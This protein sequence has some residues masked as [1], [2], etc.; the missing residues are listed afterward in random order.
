MHFPIISIMFRKIF[1]HAWC[2]S[3]RLPRKQC[4]KKI[5]T[6]FRDK[7]DKRVYYKMENQPRR[8]VSKSIFKITNLSWYLP[9]YFYGWMVVTTLQEPCPLYVSHIPPSAKKFQNKKN[10]YREK[11]S[12]I[13]IGLVLKI[14]WNFHFF[15]RRF[16]SFLPG[17]FLC[18]VA[19]VKIFLLFSRG[20]TWFLGTS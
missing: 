18:A 3:L 14:F 6:L 5:G 15:C 12:C 4:L 16:F 8:E 9:L 19:V 1:N 2:P 20:N 17:P 11:T 10:S 13:I 7:R